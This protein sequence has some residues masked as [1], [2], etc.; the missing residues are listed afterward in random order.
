[1]GDT[2][3]NARRLIL[4]QIEKLFNERFCNNIVLLR[5]ELWRTAENCCPITLYRYRP[6]NPY[7][8]DAL[9]RGEVY[10]SRICDFDDPM[11]TFPLLCPEKI[12]EVIDSQCTESNIRILIEKQYPLLPEE[13]KEKYYSLVIDWFSTEKYDDFKY[14]IKETISERVDELRQ[15]LRC[16]CFTEASESK[17][18]WNEYANSGKGFCLEYQLENGMYECE[19]NRI[20]PCDITLVTSFLPVVYDG[21]ADVYQHSHVLAGYYDNWLIPSGEEHLVKLVMALHKRPQYK[22]EKEWR[23]LAEDCGECEG[24]VFVKI[25]PSRIIVGPKCSDE[26]RACLKEIANKRGIPTVESRCE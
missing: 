17:F 11:D 24:A 10:L 9:D 15:R 14:L 6:D 22:R 2:I 20:G 26:I 7:E 25:P 4:H 8:L 18:M 19:C 13:E 12:D 5:N 21:Q 1:M 16:A 23:I 3:E